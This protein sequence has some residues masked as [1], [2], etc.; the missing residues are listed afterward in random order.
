MI[1]V[2]N[3]YPRDIRWELLKRKQDLEDKLKCI[4]ADTDRDEDWKKNLRSIIND[5][6]LVN[7]KLEMGVS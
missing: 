7:F 4:A 1:T 2:Y 5:L 6:S 3:S